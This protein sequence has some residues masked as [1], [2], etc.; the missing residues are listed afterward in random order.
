MSQY[1]EIT[2]KNTVFCKKNKLRY[3][4]WLKI[5]RLNCGFYMKRFNLQFPFGSDP[6]QTFIVIL[7]YFTSY[8]KLRLFLYELLFF[9][10]AKTTVVVKRVNF[11]V[12]KF[13][14]NYLV[15]N[16]RY[17]GYNCQ[18]AL[19]ECE[20]LISNRVIDSTREIII[21]SKQNQCGPCGLLQSFLKSSY[22]FSASAEYERFNTR[23]SFF[24]RA[25]TSGRI[26]PTII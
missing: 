18:E 3:L 26:V 22:E 14:Y 6:H 5:K 15:L 23:R 13:Q 19:F 11:R 7:T 16:K 17:P 9:H 20:F 10:A 8:L 24:T 25:K 4:V 1:N 12:F 21:Y 2:E